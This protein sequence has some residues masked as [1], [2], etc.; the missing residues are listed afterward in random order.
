MTRM[1]T[2]K[3][4]KKRLPAGWRW[5]RLG[6]VCEIIAGQSPP[7]STYRTSLEG[8]PFFQGKADFGL[9][10]P[11]PRVWCVEPNKIALP[12]DILI[13]VRAPVGPTNIADVKC[14][15]GRG[16]AAIRC[17][18]DAD[19]EFILSALRHFESKLVGKGAGSTFEA[20]S[21]DDLEQLSI[22]LP[23]LSE[24][25]RIAGVLREQMAAIEKARAAAQARL[26]A[27]KTLPASLLR[28]VFPQPGQPLP[29]GW[30]WVKLGEVI[31]IVS[32][33][34]DPKESRYRNLPHVNGENIE[35][36]TGRL[37]AV[38]SAVEDRMTSGKYLFEAG[39]VLYSKLRPYLKK[40]AIADFRGLCSA[41]MYPILPKPDELTLSFLLQ[42]FLSEPF[43]TYAESESQRARM[44]KLNRDQLL[45]YSAPLP[46]LEDQRRI[47]GVLKEQMAAVEKARASAE[48]ELNT[49]NALPA[50][51]LR[52]AFNEEI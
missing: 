40:A 2:T 19:L 32:G 24:Q 1:E 43:T 41:D 4:T 10:N 44:P 25:R 3:D 9:L 14:C 45:A 18:G 49:I 52:R 48:A 21:R 13:S 37:L 8:L 12:G 17:G 36:G 28:Q 33:Q 16:L 11:V 31:E 34:V 35:S 26:E 47:A 20:I 38:R 15:I 39:V 51:L 6:E 42:I 7:G 46:P 29:D 50:A 27:V 23:S 30:R 22:P 5:V